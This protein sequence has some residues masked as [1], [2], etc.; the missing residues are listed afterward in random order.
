MKIAIIAYNHPESSIVLAKHLAQNNEVHYFYIT[1]RKRKSIPG[2]GVLSDNNFK[3]GLNEIQLKQEHPLYSYFNNVNLKITVIAYP[4]FRQSLHWLNKLLTIAFSSKIKQNNYDVI[5]LIGQEELLCTYYKTLDNSKIVHSL[6][7]VAK[8]YNEQDFKNKLIATLYT[9][10]IPVIVHSKNSYERLLEQY[11]FDPK[12]VYNIPFGL[13]ET[14]KYFLTATKTKGEN[15]ILF[16]G[17]L[18]PYKGLATFIKAVKYAQQQVPNLKAIIAGSGTD[19]SLAEIKN[20]ATFEIINKFLDNDEIANLNEQAKMIVCPYTSASQSGIV[21]TSNVFN[22]PVIASNLGGFKEIIEN[23]DTGYLVEANDYAGIGNRIV[24]LCLD[25]SVLKAMEKN[26]SN[27]FEQGEYNWTEI[28]NRTTD[29][30]Q[31]VS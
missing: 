13:F 19:V 21:T 16:Y 27:F 14:Y 23:G 6:H 1:D 31:S 29:C 5:N 10:Q 18:Q 12:K 17:F 26:I 11:P 24:N 25:E 4:S 9:K 3:I 8:H 2:V 15:I 30:Y 22:K 20:D 28:A 7:E